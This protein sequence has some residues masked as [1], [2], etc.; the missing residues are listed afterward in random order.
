M[1][2]NKCSEACFKICIY[3][4]RISFTVLSTF[5]LWTLNIFPISKLTVLKTPLIFAC[6]VLFYDILLKKAYFMKLRWYIV[7]NFLH[8]KILISFYIW[9]ASEKCCYTGN[10]NLNILTQLLNEL[11]VLRL[12]LLVSRLYLLPG[13]SSNYFCPS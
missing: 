1:L 8:K 2:V 6:K 12:D 13:D 7:E 9:I 5:I 11:T 10:E 4:Q 3:V